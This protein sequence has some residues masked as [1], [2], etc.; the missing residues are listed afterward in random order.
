MEEDDVAEGKNNAEI[1]LVADN[2]QKLN[3]D[4][5]EALKAN[6]GGANEIIKAL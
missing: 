4:Q 3:Q 2:A 5:I 6:T 1:G